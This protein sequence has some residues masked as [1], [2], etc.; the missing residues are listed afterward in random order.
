MKIKTLPIAQIVPAKYN[1]RKNLTPKDAEYKKLKRSIE[2]FGYV[3]PIIVNERTGNVVGGHQRLKVLQDIGTKEIE[4]SVVDLSEAEEKA[5]N[6][7]LNKISGE[8]DMPLLNKLLE[9]L[10]KSNFDISL[11]GFDKKETD[12]ALE[13]SL[14]FSIDELLTSLDIDAAIEKPLWVT[15][16]TAAE[17]QSILETHLKELENKGIR[18]ERS[19]AV[20]K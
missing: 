6:I 15:I 5:L 8:W 4:V 1:P 17:N 10:S 13:K 18:V 9:D 2:K 14:P 11:T 19:Y 12:E 7:A 3:E 20:D 16:R